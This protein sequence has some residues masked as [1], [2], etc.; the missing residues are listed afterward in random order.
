MTNVFGNLVGNVPDDALTGTISIL[1][2]YSFWSFILIAVITSALV[3][4]TA[5]RM[6]GG[7]FGTVL[8]YFGAGMVL[9]LVGYVLISVP[10]C[11]SSD[12]AKILHDVLYLVGYI[13]MAIAAHRLYAFTKA[14]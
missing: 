8:H 10:V 4:V 14:Q 2:A 9:I 1:N 7:L 11:S 3:F 6:K 5:A 13:L 12:Y